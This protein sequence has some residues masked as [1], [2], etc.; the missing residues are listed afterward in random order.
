ML[1]IAYMYV[2][3]STIIQNCLYA[4][5]FFI[6]YGSD[7]DGDGDGI[8]LQSARSFQPNK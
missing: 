5:D 3:C 6:D 7:G 1:Y 2:L 4:C 8:E